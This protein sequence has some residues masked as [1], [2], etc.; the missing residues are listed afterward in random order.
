MARNQLVQDFPTRGE[1]FEGGNLIGP[2]EAAIALHVSG[3]DSD[4]TA[5]RFDGL[6]QG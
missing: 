6:G 3:K 5:L 1:G 2:H 4:Q